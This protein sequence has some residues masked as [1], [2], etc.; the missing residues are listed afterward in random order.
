MLIKFESPNL[1]HFSFFLETDT[2]K[3]LGVSTVI[4]VDDIFLL[5]RHFCRILACS[6]LFF[7]I[8]HYFYLLCLPSLETFAII[9]TFSI[10]M[11][12]ERSKRYLRN[13]TNQEDH[14]EDYNFTSR[15]K[16]SLW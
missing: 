9:S 8:R 12:I 3:K 2:G 6:L 7:I 4:L 11:P 10:F 13:N 5:W 14:H 15:C 16:V 1:F